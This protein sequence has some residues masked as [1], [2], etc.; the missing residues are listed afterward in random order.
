M[1]KLSEM[2][3]SGIPVFSYEILEKAIE[4]IKKKGVTILE[5]AQSESIDSY[6]N[7]IVLLNIMLDN[8]EGA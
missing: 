4:I 5:I 6:G 8:G 7:K 2:I 1:K 3:I